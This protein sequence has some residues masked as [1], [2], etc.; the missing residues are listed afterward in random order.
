MLILTITCRENHQEILSDNQ[1]KCLFHVSLSWESTG[2]EKF[3]MRTKQEKEKYYFL[4]ANCDISQ[5]IK[6]KFKSG[7]ERLL[8]QRV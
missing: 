7:I 3:V 6:V 8:N 1:E 5:Q 4:S 2:S